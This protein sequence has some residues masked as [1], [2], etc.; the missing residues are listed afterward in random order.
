MSLDMV[1]P[2]HFESVA[3]FIASRGMVGSV[4][5]AQFLLDGLYL[6]HRAGAALEILTSNGLRSWGNMINKLGA[7]LTGEAWD[8]SIKINMSFS[9]PWATAPANVI[10]RGMFGIIPL[11]PGFAR[12]QIKPQPASLQWATLNTPSI[13]R[14]IRVA[15]KQ[16][17]RLFEMTAS[18]PVN[19]TARILLPMK[20]GAV[21]TM[22]GHPVDGRIEN[23]FLVIDTVG[24]GSHSFEVTSGL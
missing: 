24:S 21:A 8:P 2:E 12:F 22:N 15:F 4:Y 18:I 17:G 7:T 3:N 10:P 13:K 6:S 1:D 23:G 11:E 9:H 16:T 20:E 19:T 5:L 14:P